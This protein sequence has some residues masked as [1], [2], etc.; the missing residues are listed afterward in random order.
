MSQIN[1]DLSNIKIAYNNDND[2]ITIIDPVDKS[3]EFKK[4]VWFPYIKDLYNTLL[5][6]TTEAPDKGLNKFALHSVRQ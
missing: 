1:A 3:V 5:E 6:R 4:L 2:A